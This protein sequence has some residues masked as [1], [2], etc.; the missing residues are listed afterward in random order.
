[1]SAKPVVAV[2]M[3]DPAG[4]GPEICLRVLCDEQVATFCSP[5]IIGS[6]SVLELV[7]GL[8]GAKRPTGPVFS[9]EDLL[10]GIIEGPGVVD[11][12]TDAGSIQPGV[13]SAECG[14]LAYAYVET[15]IDAAIARK[16]AAVATAPI[17]KES[18]NLAG[19]HFAGHTEILAAKT[20][21]GRYCMMLT[22]DVMTVSFVTTHTSLASVP[23]KVT[24]ER[25]CEVVELTAAAVQSARRRVPRIGV[26]G[27]NPHAG[28]HGLFGN[29]EGECIQEGIER[30]RS[31]GIDTVGPLAPDAAFT[32][33]VRRNFDAIVC[34]YHDQGHI[35]FK[36]AAFDTGVNVTLG[37]PITRTSV[38]HGTAFDIAWQGIARATSL[39][40]AI[41][42]AVVL[43]S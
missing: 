32:D 19:H 33:H 26:C 36:M 6:L 21:C 18:L 43:S 20:G 8:I 42:L 38:D 11:I 22:S 39:K 35:P 4:I 16:A 37:L 29:E 14:R 23:A 3:G 30:A 9:R 31:K 2:T 5:V 25:V 40:E 34:Q 13:C 24:P 17:N 10:S 1:M 15:G 41:R 28:E 27:L 12:A 7:S